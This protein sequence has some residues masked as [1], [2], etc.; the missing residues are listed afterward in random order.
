MSC[1]ARTT[2]SSRSIN[3]EPSSSP[4]S[5]P[6]LPVRKK[7]GELRICVD[8]RALNN[9]S[10][11]DRYP[12]PLTKET[13][14]NLSRMQ[15]FSK[16]DIIAAFNNLRIKEGQEHYTAFRTRFGLY[17]SLVMP[18]GLTGAPATFQRFIND[19]LRN[20]LDRFCSPE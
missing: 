13:L 9:V 7:T 10:E 11:K 8:Y 6:L 4:Y 20:E 17:E 5:S 14:N 15:W 3:D 12:L 18:F 16:I 2:P 1:P 19:A